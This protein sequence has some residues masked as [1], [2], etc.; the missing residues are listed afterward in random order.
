MSTKL[1]LTEFV[2]TNKFVPLNSKQ[3]EKT[4][5]ISTSPIPQE[6]ITFKGKKKKFAEQEI[7]L[8][9][10]E[11]E[12]FEK[13]KNSFQD[14]WID[15]WNKKPE[16]KKEE[17]KEI[18]L[19]KENS[20]IST[21]KK[22]PLKWMKDEHVTNCYQCHLE[23]TVFNRRHHCR[24][25]GQI[26]CWNCS[27]YF[28]DG[29]KWNHTGQI[30][31][32]S[33]CFKITDKT[34]TKKAK[35]S[36]K[37]IQ[38]IISNLGEHYKDSPQLL[39]IEKDDE[40]VVSTP[41][42]ENLRTSL[43][44]IQILDE[45]TSKHFMRI[46]EQHDSSNAKRLFDLAQII[47][48]SLSL[49]N[50]NSDITSYITIKKGMEDEIIQ[51]VGISSKVT[52]RK[53]KKEFEN[54]KILLLSCP[55]EFTRSESQIVHMENLIKQ[56]ESFLRILVDKIIE[57]KPN[58]I[59]CEHHIARTAQDFLFKENITLIINV[60]D[61]ILQKIS[62]A[63]SCPIYDSID[64]IKSLKEGGKVYIKEGLIVF[65]GLRGME[66][67]IFLKNADPNLKKLLTFCVYSVYHLKLESQFFIDQQA[68][69]KNY[70]EPE[71]LISISPNCVIPEPTHPITKIGDLSNN[72]KKNPN[73]FDIFK[74]Q[75]IISIF[76][77][78]TKGE[79]ANHLLFNPEIIIIAFYSENDRSLGTYL[80]V[81]CFDPKNLESV[82]K[83]VRAYTHDR[84]RITVS[85]EQSNSSF[86]TNDIM[87][88]SCCKKCKCKTTPQKM[89][90]ESYKMSFGK[91]LETTFYNESLVLK[92]GD[93]EHSIYQDHIRHFS[94]KD[95]VVKFEYQR[96]EIHELAPPTVECKFD[97]KQRQIYFNCLHEGLIESCINKGYYKSVIEKAKNVSSI[98]EMNDFMVYNHHLV[99]ESNESKN[100]IQI[101]LE[102]DSEGRIHLDW[103]ERKEIEV[104][105]YQPLLLGRNQLNTLLNEEEPLSI[106]SYTLESN[107][108]PDYFLLKNK[109]PKE[110]ESIMNF[111]EKYHYK[112]TLKDD[113][114]CT[115]YYA[116]QFAALRQQVLGGD[117]DF[118]ISLSRTKGFNCSGGKSGS[119]FM[120]SW[121]E[122]F[123]MKQISRTELNSFLDNGIA[124]FD[125]YSKV[126][127]QK[128][129]SLLVKIFGV[130]RITFTQK[131]KQ[132][133]YD[134]IIMENLF[135]SKNITKTFDLKGSERNRYQK[136][137][138][139]VLLDE[140]LLEIFFSG[141]PLLTKE[142]SKALLT[143]TLFNDTL[144]LVKQHI[145]DYSLLVGI[146]PE[147]HEL[148][149]G[150]IDYFRQYTWDK[151]LETWYKSATLIG[152]K[153][154]IPTIIPPKSYATRFKEA[155]N[156]FF[157][158]SPD[159][160]TGLMK[161]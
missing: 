105:K 124:F 28:I 115:A 21:P 70:I 117:D 19:I 109:T 119:I 154:Q 116:K 15:L 151:S 59:V 12:E 32:C 35:A 49:L 84:H 51:G 97:E 96:V 146:N 157:V 138:S 95:I 27:N 132:V 13:I 101:L 127:F 74:H 55:I 41:Y 47:V 98:K 22:N 150:I 37:Q 17:Q 113:I 93:C 79:K 78:L 72:W 92:N 39:H 136:D 103:R 7:I 140:N 161:I 66:S 88:W 134:V 30:R 145:M 139:S 62:N 75:S 24:I 159:K 130:Y 82:L 160:Y 53:M 20:N 71:R 104:L 3:E 128:L 135:Y 10:E 118:I 87:M 4:I 111:N 133:K 80:E 83:I 81:K 63:T 68:V 100:N 25:C 148:I 36:L 52:H 155:M 137:S 73:L 45:K 29:E 156:R 1:M 122:R 99:K 67:T 120:K 142:P 48:N 125:Y 18:V 50:K 56:E 158:L 121:D 110:I 144:F 33:F 102:S 64:K 34:N 16:P 76:T 58:I 2:V 77:K 149:V 91:F 153:N 11:K 94:K 14:P 107:D 129:P 54:A 90:L 42:E 141:D 65:K 108:Y 44:T 131:G 38:G 8:E 147:T 143:M 112:Y 46:M 85:V 60:K 5:L 6:K 89:S 69:L 40:H 86:E 61:K 114:Q 126:L 123:I 31:V 152:N 26:F 9:K 23:F 106:I 57:K 43:N